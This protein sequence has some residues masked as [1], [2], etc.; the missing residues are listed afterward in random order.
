M[1]ALRDWKFLCYDV[2]IFYLLL[3]TLALLN[4]IIEERARRY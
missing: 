4:G 1:E 2:D 3:S